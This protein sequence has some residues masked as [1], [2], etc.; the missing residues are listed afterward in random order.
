MAIETFKPPY[1]PTST[2]EKPELKL[3]EAEFGDGYTQTAGDGMNHIRK[4]ASLSWDVLTADQAREI[5]A[6]LERHGGS[7]PFLYALDEGETPLKWTCKE[8]SRKRDT[9]NTMEATFR[10]SFLL[11]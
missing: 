9:P 3:L 10:Q 4:V 8:W 5:E 7:A 11:V 2:S 1:A 6:F